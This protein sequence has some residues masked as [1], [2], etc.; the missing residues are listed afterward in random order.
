MKIF[1]VTALLVFSSV[2]SAE[3]Y[4]VGELRGYQTAKRDNYDFVSSSFGDDVFQIHIDGPRS[5]TTPR[6]REECSEISRAAISC[7]LVEEAKGL[8]EI[9]SLDLDRNIVIYSKHR[10]GFEM[11]LD[12]AIAF[13]GKILGKCK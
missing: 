2:V 6:G 12:G 11:G 4:T 7:S 3:C 8:F 1:I 10:V 9:W 5:Y 13:I